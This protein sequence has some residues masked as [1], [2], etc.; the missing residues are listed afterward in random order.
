MSG[1]T[2]RALVLSGGGPAG[3]AWMLGLIQALGR[4]G[5]DLGEAEL[6]VGTSAG[7][8]TAAQLA[9]GVLDATVDLHRRGEAPQITAPATLADFVAASMRIIMEASDQHEATRRIA[10]L[11]PLGQQLV[12]GAERKRVLAAEL[13]QSAWPEKRLAIT[14]VDADSG[15]RVVFGAD[16]GVT[17]VDALTAS[18]AL[19]GVYELVTIDGRRYADGGVHSLFNVDLAARHDTV[20]VLCPLPLNEYLQGHLDAE[21]ASLDEATVQVIVPDAESA[22]AIGPNPLSPETGR[23]ALDAGAAQAEREIPALQQV[24]LTGRGSP[25]AREV[26]RTT[27]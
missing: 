14:A 26:T 13:P 12:L 8:R 4:G 2:K 5:V 15:N 19:P 6:I 3:A 20:V 18:S 22:A 16:S 11:E 1:T 7:A 27:P 9:T 25:A 23:A 10:N 17:L 24:W 21:V